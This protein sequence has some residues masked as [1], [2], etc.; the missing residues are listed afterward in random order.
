MP[1]KLVLLGLQGAAAAGG[2]PTFD[3]QAMPPGVHLRWSFAPE[4]GFPPGG[5]WLYRRVAP[6]NE[7][8]V[9]PPRDLLPP[10]TVRWSGA[11]RVLGT[12]FVDQGLRFD[13]D[14]ALAPADVASL[15][16]PGLNSGTVLRFRTS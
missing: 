9:T 4:L 10:A 3:G 8:V 16:L 12:H 5:F 1:A 11:P 2:E 14:G 7:T 13:L 15:Q 6:P